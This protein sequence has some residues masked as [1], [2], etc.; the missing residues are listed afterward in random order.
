MGCLWSVLAV[1]AKKCLAEVCIHVHGILKCF[2]QHPGCHIWDVFKTT[3]CCSSVYNLIHSKKH[4]KYSQNITVTA[5][6]IHHKRVSLKIGKEHLGVENSA[7]IFPC[8][9]SLLLQKSDKRF[10]NKHSKSEK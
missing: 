9:K 8:S 7:I 5:P 1:A 2:V 10:R 3:C 4:Q 6:N